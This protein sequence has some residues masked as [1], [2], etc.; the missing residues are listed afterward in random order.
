VDE[1]FESARR[2]ESTPLTV[3]RIAVLDDENLDDWV[4]SRWATYADTWDPESLAALPE[5]VCAYLATR[6]F[7]WEVGN[8]GLHQYFFNYPSPE[9][10]DL[11]LDGYSF[12]GLDDARAVVATVVEP[13]AAREQEWRESL[14]DGSIETFFASYPA[15]NLPEHDDRIEFHDTERIRYVRANAT[16]FA[17]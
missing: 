14:R 3:E 7:E 13:V 4:W 16:L 8:G 12:L 11:V 1:F 9:L 5:G 2:M 10:L 15:S 17:R 6:L